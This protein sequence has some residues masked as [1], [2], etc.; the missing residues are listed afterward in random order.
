M[1]CVICRNEITEDN[2]ICICYPCQ[3]IITRIEE[4]VDEL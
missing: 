2:L 3:K 1:K 4:K